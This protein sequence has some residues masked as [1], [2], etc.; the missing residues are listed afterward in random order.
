MF[1]EIQV[2][3]GRGNP[4]TRFTFLEKDVAMASIRQTWG[5]EALVIPTMLDV[6][7]E[8]TIPVDAR[9]LGRRLAARSP[10]GRLSERGV[11]V[12]A[13]MTAIRE[14]RASTVPLDLTT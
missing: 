13:R 4:D 12:V 14:T 2:F 6:E 1:Y 11:S 10:V 8:V 9:D 3:H 5:E 7:W